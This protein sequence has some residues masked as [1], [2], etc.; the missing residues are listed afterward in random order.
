MSRLAYGVNSGWDVLN[1][2]TMLGIT[3]ASLAGTGYK[4]ADLNG[5]RMPAA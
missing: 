5:V 2:S 1:T 4:A 3:D